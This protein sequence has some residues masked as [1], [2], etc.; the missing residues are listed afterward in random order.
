MPGSDD[1]K[2][3]RVARNATFSKKIWV[4]VGGRVWNRGRVPSSACGILGCAGGYTAAMGTNDQPTGAD[5]VRSVL[6]G[7]EGPTLDSTGATQL[8][9]AAAA[10]DRSSADRLLPMVYEQ[11]RQSAQRYLSGEQAGGTLNATA[12]VH[13]AYVRLAGPR[14]LPWQNRAHF[15]AAAAEAMRRILIDRARSRQAAG[16]ARRHWHEARDLAD[17][18]SSVDSDEVLA[19]S[20]A[21]DRLEESDADAAQVVRLRFFAG[22]SVDQTAQTLGISPRSVDREWAFARAWL[23]DQLREAG[24]PG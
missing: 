17:M 8:L 23:L 12:L 24:E 7:S 10:G 4:V 11:L 15:Y 1:F 9:A 21:L 2:R 14:E 19:F 18:A 3:T 16:R 5:P 13:E 6:S 22:L 20:A